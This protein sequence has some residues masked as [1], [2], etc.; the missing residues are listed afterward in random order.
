MQTRSKYL[1]QLEELEGHIGRLGDK[2]VADIRAVGLALVGDEGAA[3]GVMEGAKASRRLRDA[4]EDGCMDI[5]LMQQPLVAD[6]LRYVTGSF[7]IVS[8]LA[9]I[10]AMARDMAYLSTQVPREATARLD[11]V[12]DGAAARVADMVARAVAAFCA[13]D[14]AA[15]QG[16]FTLDDEV[17]ELYRRAEQVVVDLIRGG[18]ADATHLPELLMVA[19]YF[20]R[21]GDDAERIADWAVFRATGEHTVNSKDAKMP[22]A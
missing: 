11:E 18:E 13:S 22:Q 21:M 15:A 2:A 4:I 3:V 9:H 14:E 1:H 8:D 16:V 17:D 20:E 10:D 7:R 19:K 6:D 5:M 12:F